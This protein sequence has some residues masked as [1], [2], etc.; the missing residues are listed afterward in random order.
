MMREESF[1]KENLKVC[2]ILF[3]FQLRFMM[4]KEADE[5]FSCKS[6]GKFVFQIF[7]PRIK[8]MSFFFKFFQK[9]QNKLQVSNLIQFLKNSQYCFVLE[10]ICLNSFET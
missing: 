2:A 9:I 4:F 5:N 7:L 1:V 3:N 8:K 6:S 10:H